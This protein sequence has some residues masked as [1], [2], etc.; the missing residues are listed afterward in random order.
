MGRASCQRLVAAGPQAGFRAGAPTP[1]PPS[2]QADATSPSTLF[3]PFLQP[4][5]RLPPDSLP[6]LPFP[7]PPCSLSLSHQP[8]KPR[9]AQLCAGKHHF[10]ILRSQRLCTTSPRTSL[11]SVVSARSRPWLSCSFS[12]PGQLAHKPCRPSPVRPART[13][14]CRARD[15]F[16]PSRFRAPCAQTPTS[17]PALRFPPPSPKSRQ[18]AAIFAEK[19]P[20]RLASRPF[21]L[22]WFW[23]VSQPFNP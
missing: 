2:P 21:T 1:A 23:C 17:L 5:R 13:L 3:I 20:S 12:R 4:T 14:R 18:N 6:C 19:S 16:H 10:K 15:P 11:K 7:L 9:S 22:P 8:Q